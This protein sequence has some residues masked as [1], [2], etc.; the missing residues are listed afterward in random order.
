MDLWAKKN[1]QEREDEEAERLVREAPKWKPPRRDKRRERMDP[2]SEHDP[3]LS[4]DPDMSLNYKN[5]GGATEE[6]PPP[7]EEPKDEGGDEEGGDEEGGDEEGGDEEGEGEEGEGEEGEGEPEE[8]EEPSEGEEAGIQAPC[9]REATAEE[10]FAAMAVLVDSIPLGMRA[11]VEGLDLHPDD[12]RELVLAYQA[13]KTKNPTTLAAKV[14]QFYETDPDRV[15]PPLSWKVE[16][17]VVPFD[18]LEKPEQEEAY[19]KHQMQIV[20]T[21]LATQHQLTERLMVLGLRG[22][23]RISPK[24]AGQLAMVMLTAPT[25]KKLRDLQVMAQSDDEAKAMYDAQTAAT[26]QMAAQTF[27]DTIA[28]GEQV[29]IHKTVAKS[30]LR[31]V[32]RNDA[33]AGMA[34]A[35]LMA[36]DYYT[37]KRMFLSR[38]LN[39]SDEFISEH[40][41]PKAIIDGLGRAASWFKQQAKVYGEPAHEGSRMFQNRVLERLMALVPDKHRQ[42]RVALGKVEAKE[43]ERAIKSWE[44]KHKSWEK[45]RLAWEESVEGHGPAAIYRVE[46]FDEPEPVEPPKP[47]YQATTLPPGQLKAMATA[48]MKDLEA[49]LQATEPPEE[50]P[51]EPEAESEESEEEPEDE[52]RKEAGQKRISTCTGTSAMDHN[53]PGQDRPAAK[54]GVYCGIDPQ[55]NDPGP[56]VG[57]TQVHQR[58]LGEKDFSAILASARVWLKQPVLAR[59]VGDATRDQQ[60]R[61][62]L[63]LAL[64]STGHDRELPIQF[65]EMLLARLAGRPEPGIGE[66]LTR[67]AT[68]QNQTSPCAPTTKEVPR[69][70]P[71]HEIRKMAAKM[72]GSNSDLAFDLSALAD[73]VALEEGS[74]T[75]AA[76]ADGKYARL[77]SLVVR[78]AAA[79][80]EHKKV[81]MPILQAI[82]ALG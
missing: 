37:A 52:G 71:S 51:E 66:T 75:A 39:P 72:A 16:G 81:L 2:D 24:I 5:V 57:W 50:E 68:P 73:R 28:S 49:R 12:M 47:V 44:K 6:K 17:T 7:D 74:R 14:S 25:G 63:D 27:K 31:C 36:N 40:D 13:T 80:G 61:A 18:A 22:Q 15:E 54:V 82:K 79:D 10:R 70:S 9:R 26:T 19:R 60:M 55:K 32:G 45:K 21:S 1:Q 69:M 4:S 67:L 76:P 33:A 59:P 30:L 46:A 42:V 29:S 77:K 62:A 58:D 41:S 11:T 23:P 38:S 56:Y 35:Y 43:Y 20:G 3:D 34:K 64:K 53:P 8:E 48:I 78:T 65:Y